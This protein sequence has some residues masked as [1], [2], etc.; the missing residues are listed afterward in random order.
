[1]KRATCLLFVL[2]GCGVRSQ[3]TTLKITPLSEFNAKTQNVLVIGETNQPWME[4][5]VLN[6]NAP[7]ERTYDWTNVEVRVRYQPV[8]QRLGTNGWWAIRFEKPAEE[9]TK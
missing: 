5:C 1:M 7:Y 3:D 8:I 9:E 6:P 2:F 4:V